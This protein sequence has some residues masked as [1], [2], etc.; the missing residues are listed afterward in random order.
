MDPDTLYV[1]RHAMERF[2]SR[3]PVAIP[4][5]PMLELRRLLFKAE[6]ED[7]KNGAVMRIIDN[8]FQ[9]A[10]YFTA[11]GWR[12]VLDPAET[13]LITVERIIYKA[14]KKR[15]PSRRK[16]RKGKEWE[17]GKGRL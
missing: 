9:G 17:D 16:K 2:L 14:A 7:L 5:N 8:G 13:R 4:G 6:S 15:R 11:E 10:S 1:T 3:S 12:F